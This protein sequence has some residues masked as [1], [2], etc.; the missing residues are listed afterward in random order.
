MDLPILNIT[1]RTL[2]STVDCT[3]H[4]KLGLEMDILV[5]VVLLDPSMPTPG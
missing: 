1:S 3:L 4:S 2:R 5:S